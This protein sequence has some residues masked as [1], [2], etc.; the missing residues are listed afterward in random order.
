MM[1]NFDSVPFPITFSKLVFIE[2]ASPPLFARSVIFF[3]NQASNP[4]D[5]LD[6]VPFRLVLVS[7]VALS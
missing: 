2:E 6:R 4:T 1:A 7:P 3:L 5:A